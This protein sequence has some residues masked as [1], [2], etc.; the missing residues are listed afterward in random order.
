MLG[1]DVPGVGAGEADDSSAGGAG[2]RADG[3]DGVG[4]EHCGAFRRL[5]ISFFFVLVVFVLLVRREGWGVG[6]EDAS[7]FEGF[8]DEVGIDEAGAG[9][10]EVVEVEA[11]GGGVEEDGEDEKHVLGHVLH[12]RLL[13][14]RGFRL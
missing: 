14:I 6:G 4:E 7:F 9:G 1:S 13:L 11:G 8:A 12:L 2:G 10:G 5:A 3:D